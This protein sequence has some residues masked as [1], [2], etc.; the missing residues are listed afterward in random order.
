MTK[1]LICLSFVAGVLSGCASDP[2]VMQ[3]PPPDGLQPV[4]PIPRP[5]VHVAPTPARTY[6]L[7]ELQTQLGMN[8][9]LQDVGFADK[10]FDGCQTA[11]QGDAGQCGNRVLTVVS[12]RLVCRDSVETTSRVP[13]SLT[14]LKS[15]SLEW[16]FAGARGH[17][18]TDGHGY[19]QVQVVSYN[20]IGAERFMMIIGTKS[21]G[22]EASEVSQIV[23]PAN[24]CPRGR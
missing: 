1:R 5:Q 24:Y 13:S 9:A 17:T 11:Y 20:P 15:H 19:G 8:R 18:R 14:P 6:N 10:E 22:I 7:R 16:R 2:T 4:S 12:F 23:L 21:V 3:L